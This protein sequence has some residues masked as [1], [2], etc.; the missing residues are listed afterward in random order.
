MI[1]RSRMLQNKKKVKKNLKKS[2]IY[3]VQ[4]LSVN[5]LQRFEYVSTTSAVRAIKITAT[6]VGFH[7]INRKAFIVR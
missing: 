6:K 7:N 2:R 1:M 3:C 4:Y 5:G